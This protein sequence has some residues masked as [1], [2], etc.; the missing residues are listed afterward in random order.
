MEDILVIPREKLFG[1]KNEN[2][3]NGFVPL[4][5]TDFQQIIQSNSLFK[6]RPE[7]ETDPSFKQIIPYIIFRHGN[8]LFTYRRLNKGNEK[9]LHGNHSIGIGGHINP[10]D[11]KGNIIMDSMKREFEEEMEYNGDYDARVLG[12]INDDS[13]DVGK[14][15]FGIVFLV[16]GKD[17]NITVK[18]KEKLEGQLLPKGEIAKL[19][20]TME[21]WS[22]LVWEWI[23][24]NIL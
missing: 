2:Y 4:E 3:F 13:N 1:L 23:K 8:R 6:P 5:K 14:V 10:I 19:E 16:E 15:H 7:M 11:T 12:Y 21:T 17:G 18:E 22:R 9:R 24:E 20:K